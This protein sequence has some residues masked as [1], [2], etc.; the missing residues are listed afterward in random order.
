MTNAEDMRAKYPVLSAYMADE[1]NRIWP[2]IFGSVSQHWDVTSSCSPPWVEVVA[3]DEMAPRGRE[4]LWTV[5]GSDPK[6]LHYRVRDDLPDE[7]N[8]GTKFSLHVKSYRNI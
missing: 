6:R 4:I 3:V 1:F 8:R 7:I 2:L 5:S